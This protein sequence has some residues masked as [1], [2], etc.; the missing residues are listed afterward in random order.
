MTTEKGDPY[1]E[2]FI[3]SQTG[4]TEKMVRFWDTLYIVRSMWT[5]ILLLRN[6]QRLWIRQTD[7][8]TTV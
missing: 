4:V 5:G 2:N 8:V 3:W 6:K 7:G 1:V